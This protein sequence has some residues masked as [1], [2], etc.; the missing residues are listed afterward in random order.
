MK[1]IK[2]ALA[3]VVIL[4]SVTMSAK[5][6]VNV[7]LTYTAD[8][9]I[10]GFW[11]KIG[12]TVIPMPLGEGAAWWPTV[13]NI[14]TTLGIGPTH[15]FIWEIQNWIYHDP[16]SNPGGFLAEIIPADNLTGPPEFSSPLSSS[17][18]DVYVYPDGS[19]SPSKFNS[20]IWAPATIY[21]ANSDPTIWNQNLNG[22]VSGIDGTAQWIWGPK[23][24]GDLGAPVDNDR[25]YVRATVQ[26]H[27]PEPGTIL[28]LG[29][30]LLGLGIFARLRRKKNK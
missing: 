21:G 27:T 19:V 11:Y 13:D 12:A 6:Q 24:F 26:T 15:E 1:K 8:N 14:T 10:T 2:I 9:E 30:G 22:P 4:F 17:S 29:S 18:W 5:A 3:V 16:G 7:T 25:V 20:L 23:N 28:L